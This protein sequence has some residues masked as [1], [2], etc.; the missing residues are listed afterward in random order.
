MRIRS[1]IATAMLL[2]AMALAQPLPE[3]DTT[4]FALLL[5]SPSAVDARPLT[6]AGRWR[7][8]S[9]VITASHAIVE[10]S[11]NEFL[12]LDGESSRMSFDLRFG[13]SDRVEVGVEVP[14]I[15]HEAGRLDSLIDEWHS[16]FGLPDGSRD[17]LPQDDLQFLFAV[18]GTPQVNEVE[19]RRGLGDTRLTL[20]LDVSPSERHRRA[21]R[22]ALALPTGQASSFSGG[23]D[24]DLS[25][26]VTGAIAPPPGSAVSLFYGAHATYVGEPGLLEDR[27]RRLIGQVSAGL[28]FPVSRRVSLVAQSTLRSPLYDA[29]IETLGKASITL[30]FGGHVDLSSTLRLSLGVTEDIQVNSAPDVSFNAGLSYRPVTSR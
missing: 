15:S 12:I 17:E 4:P 23:G 3:H 22:V 28:S 10:R 1:V 2:P 24:A 30:T 8:D 25:V 29:S 7:L 16:F 21:V 14:V 27:Y 26:G 5:A 6:K 18:D 9:S 11:G 20:G 13:V 19:R